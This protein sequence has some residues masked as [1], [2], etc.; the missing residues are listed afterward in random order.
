MRAL[1]NYPALSA[2]S[3]SENVQVELTQHQGGN[4]VPYN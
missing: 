2:E 3:P 4:C 1:F